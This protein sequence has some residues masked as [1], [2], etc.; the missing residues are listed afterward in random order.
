M[1]YIQREEYIQH[2]ALYKDKHIIKVITGVR[3]CGKSTVMLL[4]RQ[5]L[6]NHGVLP[7]QIISLNFEDY[8]FSELQDPSKLHAYIRTH[9]VPG[10]MTYVFLDEIQNVTDFQKVTDSLFLDE[11]IDLYIT[12]SNAYLLSGELATYLSGRYISIEMLPLSF[13]EY[14]S[15]SPDTLSPAEKYKLYIKNGSF[16]YTLQLDGS[17]QETTEYLRGVYSTIVLKD[18]VSRYKISDTMMLESIVRF[19]FDSIGSPLSSKKIA[20][21]MTSAGRKID[22]KTVEK[23]LSALQNSFIVYEAKRYDVKGK[24]YLQTL[25][26]Q[27]VVDVGMRSMLL[28]N[29]S[30]DADHI[31]ENIVY[32]ELVRRGYEVYT[33]KIGTEE[34]DFV[35][36]NQEGSTYIQVSATVRDKGTLERE[37]TPLRAVRD[38]YPRLLLTLDEDPDADYDGIKRTNVLDWLTNVPLRAVQLTEATVL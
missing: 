37:L 20:D 33:G 12:G 3:R 27:Y 35:A 4:Y 15:A 19:L 8:T 6:T 10:R 26:K 9:L 25:E 18:I 29:R 36:I 34:I 21:T 31:L 2:L 38:F 11:H 22:V 30:F 17:R 13:R 14:V 32:L 1:K 23:Y 16:P 24:Q 28:G 5:Y 7:E